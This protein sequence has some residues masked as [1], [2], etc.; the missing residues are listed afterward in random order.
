LLEIIHHK[1]SGCQIEE[2]DLSGNRVGEGRQV[3]IVLT[4]YAQNHRSHKLS[5]VKVSA[6]LWQAPLHTLRLS[7]NGLNKGKAWLAIIA[8]LRRNTLELV[9]IFLATSL[10]LQQLAS[11]KL[12]LSYSDAIYEGR[13][14]MEQ[15]ASQLS[16]LM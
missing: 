10:A 2:L 6:P 5:G 12:E 8:L 13:P 15:E 1:E 16:L 7:L 4:S 14:Q 11:S 3:L 9:S